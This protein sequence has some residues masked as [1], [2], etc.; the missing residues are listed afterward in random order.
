MNYP[1]H[2]LVFQQQSNTISPVHAILAI[3]QQELIQRNKVGMK[4]LPVALIR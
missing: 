2:G 4:Y 3:Q 1:A